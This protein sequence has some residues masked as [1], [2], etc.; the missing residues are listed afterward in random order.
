MACEGEERAGGP[1]SGGLP[2]LRARLDPQAPGV[3]RGLKAEGAG[4]GD[5][6]PHLGS[7]WTEGKL[8][9][10]VSFPVYCG[11]SLAACRQDETGSVPEDSKESLGR[12]FP[13]G[14]SQ[15]VAMESSGSAL[16]PRPARLLLLLILMLDMFGMN[17]VVL[18][19]PSPLLSHREVPV[20]SEVWLTQGE[21][22]RG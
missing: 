2:P 16:G 18:A 6:C 19:P 8:F 20:D 13:G 11:P 12:L 21:P 1:C 4:S 9:P 22:A 5:L 17:S 14:F 15:G 3:G 7:L 10:S